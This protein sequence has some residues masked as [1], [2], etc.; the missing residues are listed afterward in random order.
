MP[1]AADGW[2]KF[3]EDTGIPVI[4]NGAEAVESQVIPY[5]ALVAF[6]F[7]ALS[8]FCVG[9]GGLLV[10]HIKDLADQA[11]WIANFGTKERVTLY[12][13]INGKMSELH[14][15]VAQAQLDRWPLLR[16]LRHRLFTR[17]CEGIEEAG[18]NIVFQGAVNQAVPN[19]FMLQTKNASGLIVTNHLNAQ[20]VNSHRMLLPPLYSHPYWTRL[21]LA[22]A[23]GELLAP[24]AEANRTLPVC[25][26]LNANGFG[27]PFHTFMNDREIDKIVRILF[28]TITTEEI[29]S[30]KGEVSWPLKV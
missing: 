24:E 7:H 25:E 6:S 12:P 29:S 16:G 28:K 17:Y 26:K 13:G 30:A 3:I 18:I 11:R 27:L 21:T 2:D 8:P 22:K 9:E 23:D 14:A 15:A 19:I 1:V 10:S 5:K 4:I 20:A